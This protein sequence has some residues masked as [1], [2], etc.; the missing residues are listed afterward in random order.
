MNMT[1]HLNLDRFNQKSQIQTENFT[2]Y[3]NKSSKQIDFDSKEI[4]LPS[5]NLQL[6]IEQTFSIG[7]NQTNE[8]FVVH[9]KSSFY[10]I[11][12]TEQNA[13]KNK[14][15]FKTLTSQT[16]KMTS[17]YGNKFKSVIKKSPLYRSSTNEIENQHIPS[18]STKMILSKKLHS[19]QSKPKFK[20]HNCYEF[21]FKKCDKRINSN[22]SSDKIKMNNFGSLNKLGSERPI[23]KTNGVFLE[24][25]FFWKK[26]I[27]VFSWKQNG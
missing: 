25:Q 26:T 13:D 4:E 24:I 16:P 18:Y 3:K 8:D 10:K 21:T 27:Y 23:V 12:N 5:E 15:N 22:N 11:K 14:S 19:F 20:I 2:N 7:F 6:Q 1:D 17:S 9:K